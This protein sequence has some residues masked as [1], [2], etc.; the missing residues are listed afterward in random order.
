MPDRPVTRPV[1][2]PALPRLWRDPDV[3][4]L[5]RTPADA[6]LLRVDRA[7]VPLLD[8]TRTTAQLLID[9][10]GSAQ[11]LA[12]LEQAGLVLDADDLALPGVARDERD[13]LAPDLAS[14]SLVHGRSASKA[15][16]GRRGA[17]VVVHGAGRVGGPL[18]AQLAAAGVGTVDVRDGARARPGDTAVG[19]L[20]AD[21][22]GRTRGEAV[23]ARLR[24]AGSTRAPQ[25]VVLAD[26][27]GPESADALRASGTPHLVARVDERTGTVGPLVLP[28]RS[29]CLRCLELTRTALDPAWPVLSAQLET[30]RRAP[31]ACDGVLAA[32]V[33]SQAALQ[34]LE[35]LEGG[36]PASVGGTLELTL[37]GWRWQRRSWPRHPGCSC[38]RLE[39]RAA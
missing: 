39:E 7:L 16:L 10:P 33:A 18:A 3:L 20:T 26:D 38:S 32:A 21:D 5:G 30:P 11:A 9:S 8:G 6:V 27:A 2:A 12:E 14:L 22:V 24:S 1:L 15:L 34:V 29:S 37:P 4:Q 31:R 25:L 13:R 23:T 28:G 36:V 19:G 35:L 17:R